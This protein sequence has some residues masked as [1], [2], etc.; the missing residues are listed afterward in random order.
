MLRYFLIVFCLLLPG[1][2]VG[3]QDY[4][5]EP[6]DSAYHERMAATRAAIETEDFE[7]ALEHLSWAHEHFDFAIVE[8]ATARAYHRLERFEDAER[9]YTQFLR[10]FEACSNESG[11]RETAQQY[12]SLALQQHLAALEAAQPPAPEEPDPVWVADAQDFAGVVAAQVVSDAS[13]AATLIPAHS[14]PSEGPDGG[15]HPAWW[16]MGAGG[17]LIVGGLVYDL[18]QMGILDE[19]DAAAAAGDSNRVNQL[20]DEIGTIKL[21]DGILIGVGLAATIGGA[22]YYFLDSGEEAPTESFGVEPEEGGARIW[23]GH[24]F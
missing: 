16:V 20:N 8:F 13:Y 22:V 23:W 10:H 6:A 12:H 19:R 5:V 9:M 17:A 2:L 15:V 18:T 21:V 14:E 11:L 4:C 1:R 7:L 24:R 3:A